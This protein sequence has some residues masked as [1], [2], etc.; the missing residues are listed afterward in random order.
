MGVINAIV[1]WTQRT[2]QPLGVWGLFILAFI[3]SSFFPVPPDLLLVILALESPESA[4]F[5]ALITTIGSVLGGM[6]GYLIGYAGEHA[7]LERIVSR[8][9]IDHVHRLF[10]KYEA[11]AIFIAGFT[12]IPYK[13]FTIASGVFYVNFKVFVLMSVL[14]RG[15]RFFAEALLIMYFGRAIMLFLDQYFGLLTIVIVLVATIVWYAVK[16]RKK[17][18]KLLSQGSIHTP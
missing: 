6:F 3:E 11:W 5:L 9:K 17:K 16:Q 8:K 10:N 7:V 18:A 2:L 15:A 1:E 4:L 14:S 13:V 12:P